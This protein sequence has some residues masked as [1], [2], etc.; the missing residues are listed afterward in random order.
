MNTRT[1]LLGCLLAMA[2]QAQ[3]SKREL[4]TWKDANGVTQYSDRPVPGAKKV[5]LAGVSS[6]PASAA[7]PTAEAVAP[8]A[9]AAVQAPVRYRALEFTSPINEES[10]FGADATVPVQLRSDP[11]L[12]EG[13]RVV[14]YL[15]GR[16]MGEGYQHT[17]AELER[18]AHTLTAVIFDDQGNERMRSA[19]LV[20][21]VK[22]PTNV[23]PRAQ[24]PKVRP[25]PPKPA[26]R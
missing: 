15:D 12:A 24:G 20:F 11:E 2:V 23:A 16:E 9:R 22:P 4:W 17:L 25:P 1:L 13:H 14:L 26:P 5:E 10:F 21:Y 19:P 8:P 18:G 7:A 3:E 6:P